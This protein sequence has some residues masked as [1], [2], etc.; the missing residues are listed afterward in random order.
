[1]RILGDNIRYMADKGKQF[2]LTEEG[3]ANSATWRNYEVGEPVY[4]S[5]EEVPKWAVDKGYLIE[6]PIPG[7]KTTRGWKVVY[8]YKGHQLPCG[9]SYVF[10][11][12]ELA[13]N[14]KEYYKKFVKEPYIVE[15]V[16][17][18]LE[19][20]ECGLYKGKKVYNFDYFIT[21]DA[22]KVGDYLCNEY[23]DFLLDVLPPIYLTK[24]IIQCSEPVSTRENRNGLI[25]VTYTTLKRVADEVWE[26]CGDCCKGET[27]RYGKEERYY[28]K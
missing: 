17:S 23:A 8:D 6:V 28:G 20:S 7:W 27:K 2:V 10:P 11:I 22:F 25:K 14:Y 5:G 15:D 12:Y 13:E 19:L 1:M 4:L 21:L 3:K 18:G 16:Y 26:Y 24:N 9:N